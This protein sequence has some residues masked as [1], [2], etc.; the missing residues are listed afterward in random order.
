M[1]SN[2]YDRQWLPKKI[3]N[4]YCMY[5]VYFVY[6]SR[7][8]VL[9][10]LWR[11]LLCAMNVV[12]AGNSVKKRDCTAVYSFSSV[13]FFIMNGSYFLDLCEIIFI[14]INII[15]LSLLN[16]YFNNNKWNSLLKYKIS[17][18]TIYVSEHKLY[19][20]LSVQVF[21]FD[22]IIIVTLIL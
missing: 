12:T 9:M 18:D 3:I 2:I 11:R 21:S 17:F 7:Q 1:I 20:E 8:G 22:Y 19:T 15:K 16:C 4:L 6:R 10:N 13:S 5:I 14:L